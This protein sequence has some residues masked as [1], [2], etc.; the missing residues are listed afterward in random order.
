LKVLLWENDPRILP[1]ISELLNFS[2]LIYY[3]ASNGVIYPLLE[4]YNGPTTLLF[5]IN[6]DIL[7]L[8]NWVE[9]W[10][11]ISDLGLCSF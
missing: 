8:F 7:I 3:D 4:T 5:L 2:I 11:V 6:K 9:P 10:E 1:Q